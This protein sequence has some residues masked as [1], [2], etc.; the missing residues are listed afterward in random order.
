LT[1]TTNVMLN[2]TSATFTVESDTLIEATVPPGATTGY[3]SVTTPTGVLTSNV[4]FQ[5]IP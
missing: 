3:V 1:G 4:P 2:G 5:V